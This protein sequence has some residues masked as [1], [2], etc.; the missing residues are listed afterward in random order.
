[1]S[2]MPVPSWKLQ[3]D[4]EEAE[5][6]QARLAKKRKKEGKELEARKRALASA[7]SASSSFAQR[8]LG[9]AA[10]F[11]QATAEVPA[12]GSSPVGAPHGAEEA[13]SGGDGAGQQTEEH[14]TQQVGGTCRSVDN[15]EKDKK[16]GEGQ[17]GAVYR[18]KDKK[19][20]EF[21]A[22]KKVFMEREREGFP[23]TALREMNILMAIDHPYIV[24][25]KEI[26]V[27]SGLNSIFMVMELLDHDLRSVLDKQRQPFSQAEVK[28]LMKQ[29]LSGY[30][31]LTATVVHETSMDPSP[32]LAIN[33]APPQRVQTQKQTVLSI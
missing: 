16:M 11:K 7:S 33:N 32:S 13:A 2:R 31:G 9:E 30:A 5:A 18:A 6:E 15:Y 24:C 12:G 26:C 10:A 1:M 19:T 29:L 4:D 23:M 21:V 25:V 14:S 28:T 3:N 8:A 27:G 20:G 22:L 17:Y